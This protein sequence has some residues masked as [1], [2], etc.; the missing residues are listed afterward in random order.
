M[1]RGKSTNQADSCIGG[2][3]E[4]VHR[5]KG[6]REGGKAGG[7]SSQGHGYPSGAHYKTEMSGVSKCHVNYFHLFLNRTT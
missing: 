6:E 7:S 4:R 3:K 5:R 2:R 1:R